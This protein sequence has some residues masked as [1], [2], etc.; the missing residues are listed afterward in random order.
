MRSAL[1]AVTLA[2]AF[3]LSMPDANGQSAA[4]TLYVVECR[5]VTKS[6]E[7]K[8]E[9]VMGPRLVVPEGQ[10][11]VVNEV[12]QTPVV[13]SVR[14]TRS[15]EEPR[16]TI[17]KEGTSIDFTVYAEGEGWVTLDATIETSKITDLKTKEA[18]GGR[19][20]QCALV[21]SR[22]VRVLELAPVGKQFAVPL[23]A[24]ADG[25]PRRTVE[26]VV[27]T[28]DMP[29]HRF[30]NS[31]DQVQRKSWLSTMWLVTLRALAAQ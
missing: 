13:A 31:D 15:G 16:I 3:I 26:F 27:S 11:G 30:L 12:R 2:T 9:V 17:L 25:E 21:E 1:T 24:T 29:R 14:R 23:A 18:A 19:Q 7:G 22:R 28:P 8:R 20:R 6:A 4:E 5:L 10:P